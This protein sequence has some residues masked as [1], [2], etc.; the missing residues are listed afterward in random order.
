MVFKGATSV[1]K[2]LMTLVK[3]PP[4]VFKGRTVVVKGLKRVFK[5]WETVS[6]GLKRVF[7][8]LKSL[9]NPRKIDHA[10]TSP[11]KARMGV[12]LA[13]P[14]RGFSRASTGYGPF[15][16]STISRSYRLMLSTDGPEAALL[17]PP[18][19]RTR[20]VHTRKPC[21]TCWARSLVADP[22]FR[23]L[24]P[25]GP[26]SAGRILHGFAQSRLAWPRTLW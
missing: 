17:P 18:V 21:H 22:N 3:G 13:E 24:H 20:S 10:P 6:K 16:R 5:G 25:N 7:K 8:P 12:A 14:N 23:R 9:V 1:F 15:N 19:A 11:R 2:G 4:R 26:A